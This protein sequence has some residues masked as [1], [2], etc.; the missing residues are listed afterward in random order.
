M[1]AVLVPG[2]TAASAQEPSVETITVELELAEGTRQRISIEVTSEAIE[3]RLDELYKIDGRRLIKDL[4]AA[5]TGAHAPDESSKAVRDQALAL[6]YEHGNRQR[7]VVYEALKTIET[8]TWGVFVSCLDQARAQLALRRYGLVERTP[9]VEPPVASDGKSTYKNL[10]AAIAKLDPLYREVSKYT[11]TIPPNAPTA[12]KQF[13]QRHKAYTDAYTEALGQWPALAVIGTPMMR[14]LARWT[15][16]D[17]K[18]WAESDD[19][20]WHFDSKLR[21]ELASAWKAAVDNRPGFERDCAKWAKEAVR[22]AGE[23]MVW[24]PEYAIG[25]YHPLWRHPFIVMAALERLNLRPGSLGYAAAIGALQYAEEQEERRRQSKDNTEKLLGW[26][27]AGFGLLALIP[28]VGLFATAAMIATQAILTLDHTLGYLDE[29][30]RRAAVGPMASRFGF[31]DADGVG[32]L[33]DVLGLAGD[34]LPI[35]GPWLAKLSRPAGVMVRAAAVQLAVEGA[36]HAAGVAAL[37]VSVNAAEVE[38][39]ARR[40][41]LDQV[42]GS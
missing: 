21:G 12:K 6:C 25:R 30:T 42:G 20:G 9:H 4:E 2:P 15:A 7:V 1:L 31:A 39:Q 29:S 28:V 19:I 38:R 13:D 10:R 24:P 14:Y 27:V 26:A 5:L 34:V 3:Q 35:V 22:V 32:L 36:G 23:S 37:A 33:C 11:F 18:H 8:I 17:V 41:G 40:V 16:E